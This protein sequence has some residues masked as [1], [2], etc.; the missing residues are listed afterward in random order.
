MVGADL[1]LTDLVSLPWK[2][3]RVRF[4]MPFGPVL[5]RNGTQ[6]V[7]CLRVG[8]C[9]GLLVHEHDGANGDESNS[10]GALSVRGPGDPRSDAVECH[11]TRS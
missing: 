7:V 6:C 3:S 5:A 11:R 9:T 2:I 8:G 10:V 4:K 1:F